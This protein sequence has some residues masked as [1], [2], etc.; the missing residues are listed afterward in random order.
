MVWNRA[1]L[2]FS[3]IS[4]RSGHEAAYRP[5]LNITQ[6]EPPSIRQLPLKRI[7]RY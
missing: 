5:H 2:M 7:L 6:M 3:F 4:E 1:C